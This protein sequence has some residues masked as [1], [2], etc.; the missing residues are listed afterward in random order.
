MNTF[1]KYLCGSAL[2]LGL[3]SCAT[4]EPTT[5]ETPKFEGNEAVV[6]IN[7]YAATDVTRAGADGA[8]TD[9]LPGSDDENLVRKLNFYFYD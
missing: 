7:I 4:D 1:I 2:L 8:N 5:A 3:W 9:Y 6:H